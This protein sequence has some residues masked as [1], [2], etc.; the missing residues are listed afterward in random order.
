VTADQITQW[1][2]LE[3]ISYRVVEAI[4]EL[5][6]CNLRG[7]AE[8]VEVDRRES[9]LEETCCMQVLTCGECGET[10]EYSCRAD[11]EVV[12]SICGNKLEGA[13]EELSIAVV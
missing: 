6:E 11:E 1:L 12:C 7:R 13:I 8:F 4:A 2:D 9:L 5:E 10:E 3:G